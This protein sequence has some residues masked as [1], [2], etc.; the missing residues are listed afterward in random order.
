MSFMYDID[1]TVVLALT[2]DPLTCIVF[3]ICVSL[4]AIIATGGS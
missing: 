4:Q 3:S 1:N 2:G